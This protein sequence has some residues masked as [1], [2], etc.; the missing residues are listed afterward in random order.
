MTFRVKKYTDETVFYKEALADKKTLKE[1]LKD[2]K[3]IKGAE[4]V[5]TEK[6]VI[7]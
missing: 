3:K 4:L 5:R 1:L 7:K 2:G 6:L